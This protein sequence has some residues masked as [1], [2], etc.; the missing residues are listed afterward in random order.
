MQP[1]PGPRQRP[2]HLQRRLLPGPSE[3][4]YQQPRER[5]AR[6]GGL[7]RQHVYPLQASFLYY[8]SSVCRAALPSVDSARLGAIC[9]EN[10]YELY[11]FLNSSFI[12]VL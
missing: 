9:I 10:V 7:H 6:G 4:L 2:P 5:A 3:A 11:M 1:R 8:F 12:C